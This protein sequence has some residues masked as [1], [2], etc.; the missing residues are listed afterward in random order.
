[1][2]RLVTH[3]GAEVVAAISAPLR[4]A[5]VAAEAPLESVGDFLGRMLSSLMTG[6]PF[7]ADGLPTLDELLAEAAAEPVLK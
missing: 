6:A 5:P 3:F 4:A 7:E 1:M 2:P